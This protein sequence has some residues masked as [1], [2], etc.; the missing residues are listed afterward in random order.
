[1]GY[2]G[3]QFSI[4]LKRE[5]ANSFLA[6]CWKILPSLFP[7]SVCVHSSRL[8]CDCSIGD[9]GSVLTIFTKVRET[10]VRVLS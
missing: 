1:M 4:A 2:V 6:H 7:Y 8:L 10:V 5:A 3:C 9:H